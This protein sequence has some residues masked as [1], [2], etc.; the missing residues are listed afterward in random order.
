MYA[1]GDLTLFL[2][3]GGAGDADGQAN[4]RIVDP[5]APA[6]PRQVTPPATGGGKGG[7]GCGSPG[8][9]GLWA[10]ALAWLAAAARTRA[11]VPSQRGG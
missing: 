7:C 11:Q 5:G 2:K 4:G 9:A 6:W 10:L 3:D 8:E 1:A